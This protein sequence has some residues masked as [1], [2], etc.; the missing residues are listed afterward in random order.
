M[1]PRSVEFLPEA[2]AELA[3]L[4]VRER[5]AVHNAIEKL[6]LL[7][8]EL[9]FPH[10]SAVKGSDAGLRELRPRAGRSA[11]RALYRRVG[12]TMVVEAIGPEAQAN[13]RGF[14]KMTHLAAER[15]DA[16]EG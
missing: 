15:L 5:V 1:P 10:T 4:P 12:E 8:E 11:W 6:A 13:S 7:G 14:D 16:L 3:R 9:G 2:E